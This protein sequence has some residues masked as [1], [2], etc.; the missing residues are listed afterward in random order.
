MGNDLFGGLGGLVGGLASLMPQDDP[1]VK[2]LTA[3]KEVSDLQAQE[4]EVY[5]EIGRRVFATDGATAYPQE[6]DKLRLIQSNIAAAQQKLDTIQS[7]QQAAEAQKEQIDSARTCPQCGTV[8]AAGIN[9]C[10]ECGAKLGVSQ[11]TICPACGFENSP[12]TRF[13][14]DCGARLG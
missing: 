10:Q 8:N 2:L 14:G 9:F 4:A 7:E 13:C 3:Q 1:A 6:A 5:T 11:K 12:N